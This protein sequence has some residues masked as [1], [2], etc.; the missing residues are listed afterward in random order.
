M[1]LYVEHRACSSKWSSLLKYTHAFH[2]SSDLE[3]QHSPGG[4]L[5]QSRS[6]E[7]DGRRRTRLVTD[8]C[9]QTRT[10]PQSLASLDK[11]RDLLARSVKCTH[12]PPGDN[13][14]TNWL[15]QVRYML[16]VAT[17]PKHSGVGRS[18]TYEPFRPSPTLWRPWTA[19]RVTHY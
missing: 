9:H 16:S 8:R 4:R 3:F 17:F 14:G 19:T 1:H 5:R 7:N 12:A 18:T 11:G 2:G 6:G 13:Y 15:Y 10:K